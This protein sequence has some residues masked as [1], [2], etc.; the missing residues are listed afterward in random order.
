MRNRL[1]K[2]LALLFAGALVL[3]ACGDDSDSDD[4]S[5]SETTE[6]VEEEA[7]EEEEAAEA[8]IVETAAAAGDFTTLVA[9]VEAA[10]LDEAL[11]GEGP[12]TV[13]APTDAA[14]AR[15]PAGTV[16]NLV[17][18]ENKDKLVAILK[19]HVVSG[20]VYSDQALAAGKA[21][22][23]QGGAL[24]IAATKK[25]AKVGNAGLVKTDIDTTNGVIH[26]ID[27]VL[28]PE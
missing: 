13:F 3:A 6:A 20:R 4:E 24:E 2:L 14:F 11:A 28:L 9:A 18:P 26:V 10:G 7:P 21:S 25:G 8:N 1:L 16:E 5:S 17:K 19:Y 22:T 15:L 12:F 27:T 23:L